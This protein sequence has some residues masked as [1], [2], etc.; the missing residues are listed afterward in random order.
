LTLHAA[1]RPLLL[2]EEKNLRPQRIL[3]VLVSVVFRP[4]VTLCHRVVQFEVFEQIIA[5]PPA[6]RADAASQ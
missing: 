4:E 5:F 6:A 2:G 1:L 3:G